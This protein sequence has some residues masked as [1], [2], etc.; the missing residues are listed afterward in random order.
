MSTLHSTQPCLLQL[1][2][3]GRG[4]WHCGERL[5][6]VPTK[7][8]LSARARAAGRGWTD[9]CSWDL[10]E[11][12]VIAINTGTA[13]PLPTGQ[14]PL[15]CPGLGTVSTKSSHQGRSGTLVSKDL[16][17]TLSIPPPHPFPS[18][19]LVVSRPSGIHWTQLQPR[20]P[21]A[22]SQGSGG[23]GGPFPPQSPAFSWRVGRGSCSLPPGALWC[24]G[25]AGHPRGARMLPVTSGAPHLPRIQATCPGPH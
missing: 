21:G 8:L 12:T 3:P 13:K 6:P 23:G 1:S 16:W 18:A 9:G 4:S 2:L 14:S 17:V 11:A 22:R 10:F 20:I 5:D 15:L 19:F 24:F 25:L 7:G